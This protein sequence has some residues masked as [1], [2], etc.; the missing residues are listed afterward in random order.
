MEES[1][2]N[3]QENISALADN[4]F[5]TGKFH[6]ID[7]CR[8]LG[9]THSHTQLHTPKEFMKAVADAGFG[10]IEQLRTGNRTSGVFR[11]RRFSELDS[12]QTEILQ[13]LKVSRQDYGSSGEQNSVLQTSSSSSV[14]VMSSTPGTSTSSPHCELDH[15]II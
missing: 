2:V 12:E 8:H 6:C 11:K 1:A 4:L 14:S 15:N 5:G 10:T 7:V 9:I 13:Q 3:S